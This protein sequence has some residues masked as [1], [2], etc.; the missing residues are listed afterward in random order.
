MFFEKFDRSTDL[1]RGMAD[2][3]GVDLTDPALA[4]QFR[5]MVMACAGCEN[6]GGCAKLQ[7]ANDTLDS[8]PDYCQ[9]KSV[10]GA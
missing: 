10:F 5:Q 4:V 2:R 9:N 6:Q 3:T 7:A 8:A 1:V